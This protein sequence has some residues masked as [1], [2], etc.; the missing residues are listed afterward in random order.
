MP[1]Y[2]DYGTIGNEEDSQAPVNTIRH[3]QVY[4]ATHDGVGNSLPL[5]DR[6]FISFSYGGKNI[7]D[8]NLIAT[9]NGDRLQKNLYASF[10]D[11]ITTSDIWDGQ[12]YWSTHYEANQL[13][14]TLSTDGITEKELNDFL[15]WF[16]PGIVKEL[17]LAEHPNRAIMA[18]VNSAPEMSMLPFEEKTTVKIAGQDYETSTTLYKGDITLQLIMDDPFWY[19]K[20]NLFKKVDDEEKWEDAFYCDNLVLDTKDIL[21]IVQE[22]NIPLQTMVTQEQEAHFLFGTESAVGLSRTN[23]SYVNVDTNID[24]NNPSIISIDPIEED[25]VNDVAYCYYAGTAPCEPIIKFTL[26]PE[27]EE[28]G[29]PYIA[30]PKNSFVDNEGQPYNLIAIEGKTRQYLAFSTPS[31]YTAYN[32]VVKV[33][34]TNEG[35]DWETIRNLIRDTVKHWAP[36]QYAIQIINKYNNENIADQTSLSQCLDDFNNFLR[37]EEG[38]LFPAHFIINCKTGEAKGFFTF[39]I[40]DEPEVEIEILEEN[41]GDMIKSKYIKLEEKNS[42]TIDGMITVW[43][44]EHPEYSYRIYTDCKLQEFNIVYKYLYL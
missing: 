31:I 20:I 7:E 5:M 21:K 38:E 11:N 9:I 17:I 26:I 37:D 40:S 4:L 10:K 29:H 27:R 43:T 25:E 1:N 18:R 33:L 14:F 2:M 3:S 24:F 23:I 42:P 8:F 30:I 36:R 34:L 19:S 12:F 44:Q 32:Q 6:S 16:K 22:D 28:S 13:N 15:M 41:V 39:R 35:S